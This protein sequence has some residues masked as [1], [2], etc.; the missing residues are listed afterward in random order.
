MRCL[1]HEDCV[2]GTPEIDIDPNI[3]AFA[4]QVRKHE[5]FRVEFRRPFLRVQ[6]DLPR[7][8]DESPSGLRY[9]LWELIKILGPMNGNPSKNTLK[10]V[11]IPVKYSV[12]GLLTVI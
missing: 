1:C 10:L 5:N 6:P 11:C 12:F 9:L 3:E 8:R 2:C 7:Q 4:E